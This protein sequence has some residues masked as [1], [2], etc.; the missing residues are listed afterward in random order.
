M[1]NFSLSYQVLSMYFYCLKRFSGNIYIYIYIFMAAVVS[2]I[3][4]EAFGRFGREK[5]NYRPVKNAC[6]QKSCFT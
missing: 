1:K 5:I 4:A 6:Y 2:F 3:I